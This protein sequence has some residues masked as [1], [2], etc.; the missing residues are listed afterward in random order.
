[1]MR[2]SLLLLSLGLLS[3]CSLFQ[4]STHAPH[5]SREEAD[6]Y[7]FPS[8]TFEAGRTTVL[9]G[10]V[11]T[12]IQLAMDDFL[13][14]GRKPPKDATPLQTCLYRRDIYEVMVEPQPDG[15]IL[16]AIAPHRERCDPNDDSNDTGG[17][18]AVDPKRGLIIAEQR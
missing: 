11:A 14:L 2:S 16:V 13:P 8:V 4:R 12:A 9:G 5:A 15:I 6:R 3:G 18:Y 1:M 17:I 7:V 10:D